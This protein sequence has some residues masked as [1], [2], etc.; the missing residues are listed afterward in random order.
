[1]N[2]TVPD[3]VLSA[4]GEACAAS[5]EDGCGTPTGAWDTAVA[6]I[7]TAILAEREECARAAETK[8]AGRGEDALE[9]AGRAIATDIRTRG[10]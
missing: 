7:R 10:V 4:L 9:L 3:Y 1:M 8:Y 2:N 5:A 6:A